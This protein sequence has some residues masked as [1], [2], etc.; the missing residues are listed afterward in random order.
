MTDEHTNPSPAGA[1]SAPAPSQPASGPTGRTDDDLSPEQI[2][3]A[4]ERTAKTIKCFTLSA[5]FAIVV[6]LGIAFYRL[7]DPQAGIL[8]MRWFVLA[9]IAIAGTVALGGV[10][11]KMKRGIRQQNLR[12][13]GILLVLLLSS[14]LAVVSDNYEPVYGLLGGVAGYLFGKDESARGEDPSV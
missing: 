13:V 1:G 8:S 11:I 7:D 14:M 6:L 9:I 10:F 3:A 4:L 2:A 12:A 5:L